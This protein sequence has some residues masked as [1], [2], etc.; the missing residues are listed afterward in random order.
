MAQHLAPPPADGDEIVLLP[1]S[2]AQELMWLVHRGTPESLAYNMPRTRR[3]RGPIDIAA[4]RRAFD[5]VVARHEIL[6]TTYRTHEDVVLQVIHPATQA[7]FEVV[8]LAALAPD[9]R[10][11]EAD[12]VVRQRTARPFDLGA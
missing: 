5:A 2:Y 11:A 1:A 10:E 3:L 4:L 6:R 12:R 8:D 7:P 9:D